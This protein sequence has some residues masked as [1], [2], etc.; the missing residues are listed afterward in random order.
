M[1]HYRQLPY[2]SM[3]D[4]GAGRLAIWR[5]LTNE[6]AEEISAIV[7]ELF[8]E[9]RPVEEILMD[10]GVAFRS[11]QFLEL[12]SMWG[13]RSYFK[14]AYRPEGNGIVE[15]HHRTIKRLFERANISPT[16]AVY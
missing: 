16:E 1:T 10:N 2:L 8:L 11:Q 5:R 13:V 7:D 4:Y 3:V 12:L 9:R 14:A 15:R 6:I